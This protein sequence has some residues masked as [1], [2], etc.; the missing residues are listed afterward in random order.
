MTAV[1]AHEI[2]MS[3]EEVKD[4]VANLRVIWQS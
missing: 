2:F 4:E 1:L 3:L